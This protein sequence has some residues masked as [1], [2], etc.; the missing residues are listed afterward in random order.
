MAVA[1][2]ARITRLQKKKNRMVC[3]RKWFELPADDAQSGMCRG[4]CR[5]T[6]GKDNVRGSMWSVVS[7]SRSW[8]SSLYDW[9]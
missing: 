4:R 2:T 5:G 8:A 1:V 6:G 9:L 7:R 3:V